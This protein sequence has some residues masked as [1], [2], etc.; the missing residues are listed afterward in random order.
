MTLQ[1]ESEA[2]WLLDI[3]GLNWMDTLNSSLIQA[4]PAEPE[5]LAYS[6]REAADLLGVDS[7]A[8]IG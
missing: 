5:R 8:C 6:I 2:R 3:V 1:Y 7:L 4:T